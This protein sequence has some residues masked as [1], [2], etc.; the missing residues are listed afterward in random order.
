M[1][2]TY[3]GDEKYDETMAMQCYVANVSITPSALRN[4]GGAGFVE[5]AKDFLAKLDLQT[6]REKDT[7]S[8]PHWLNSQTEALLEKFGGK[9]LWGPARKSVNI[10]MVMASLNRFLCERYALARFEEALEVPIDAIVQEK[11][12]THYLRLKLSAD[13]ELPRWKGIKWMLP[14]ENGRYQIAARLVAGNLGIPRGR[15]DVALWGTG[16]I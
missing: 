8:Y 6:L 2:A 16:P 14:E 9:S 7:S 13:N 1:T 4:L 15:L 11:L 5:N 12:R 10:F 3:G